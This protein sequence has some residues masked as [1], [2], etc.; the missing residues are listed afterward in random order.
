VGVPPRQ[1]K[2]LLQ[3]VEDELLTDIVV[4]DFDRACAEEFGR[5]RGTL[6]RQGIAVNTTIYKSPPSP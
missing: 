1:S 2:V 6:L 3:Q 5:V 4:L